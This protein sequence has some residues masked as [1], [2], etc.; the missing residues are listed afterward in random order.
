MLLLLAGSVGLR[1]DLRVALQKIVRQ[2]P[3]HVERASRHRSVARDS[4]VARSPSIL[5]RPREASAGTQAASAFAGSASGAAVSFAI[6][7]SAAGAAKSFDAVTFPSGPK[8][9]IAS[10]AWLI[11]RK[12]SSRRAMCRAASGE[13]VQALQLRLPEVRQ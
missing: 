7:G 10:T 3:S 12:V 11:W 9:H 2:P 13:P 8:T 6:C 5:V 1:L 4:R